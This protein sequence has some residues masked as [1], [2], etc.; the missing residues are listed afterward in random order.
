MSRGGP[1]R[2]VLSPLLWITVVDDL[3]K[4]LE[5]IIYQVIA[6]ADDVALIVG[7]KFL[8]TLYERTEVP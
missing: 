1:K 5:K 2:E 4:K 8:K 7:G 6:Y 3:L